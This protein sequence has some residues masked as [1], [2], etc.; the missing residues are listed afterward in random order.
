MKELFKELTL[1]SG[2]GGDEVT[3]AG[4]CAANSATP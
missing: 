3:C 1:A 2:A 4:L